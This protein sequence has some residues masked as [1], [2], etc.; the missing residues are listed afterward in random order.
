[1]AP[2]TGALTLPCPV[3]PWRQ[4][5]ASPVSVALRISRQLLPGLA[6]ALAL[7]LGALW[8]LVP[9]PGVPP[10]GPGTPVADGQGAGAAAG[11]DN[12]YS[13]LVEAQDPSLQMQMEGIVRRQV[14][15]VGKDYAPTEAYHRDP[16]IGLS[17]GATAIRVA[18]FYYRLHTGTLVGPEYTRLMLEALSRPGIS[19]KFV[20]GLK[21]IPGIAMLRKP[22]TWKTF[23]ADSALVHYK[24]QTYIIVGL[25]NHE[26][27]DRWLS[28]LASPLNDLVRAE[29]RNTRRL[30]QLTKTDR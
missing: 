2:Q 8:L 4:L 5:L 3:N 11:P 15:W 18:R 21:N 14:L 22:G 20:K 12:S 28:Q 24:D 10:V 27:G 19:H 30:A 7:I 17:R 26:N 1:M 23:H 29:G 25:A 13:L 16:L 6:L 9:A